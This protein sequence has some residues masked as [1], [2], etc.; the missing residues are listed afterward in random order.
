[1]LPKKK[2]KGPAYTEPTA[3]TKAVRDDS[4]RGITRHCLSGQR[5]AGGMSASATAGGRGGRPQGPAPSRGSCLMYLTFCA[6]LR[7]KRLTSNIGSPSNR[8]SMT[9]SGCS[10]C[11]KDTGVPVPQECYD[12]VKTSFVLVQDREPP[13][14]G[15]D[16]GAEKAAGT[17]TD[18]ASTGQAGEPQKAAKE[19]GRAA[20]PPPCHQHDVELGEADFSVDAV[21]DVPDSQEPEGCHSVPSKG[22]TPRKEVVAA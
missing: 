18:A 9:R 19:A 4:P 12:W 2:E 16:T 1:M 10:R 14:E 20:R 8:S 11:P 3:P 13:A 22:G 21:I 5:Q 17:S 6:G 15:G 7:T